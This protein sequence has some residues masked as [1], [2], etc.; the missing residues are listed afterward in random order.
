MFIDSELLRLCRMKMTHSPLE[1]T[2][3]FVQVAIHSETTHTP[4]LPPYLIWV[5]HPQVTFAVHVL[6]PDPAYQPP[7]KL[8]LKP[9]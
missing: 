1:L 7:G 8:K 5:H 4:R 2:H 9:N 3:P 6:A